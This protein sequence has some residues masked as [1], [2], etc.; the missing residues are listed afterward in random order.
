MKSQFHR[1]RK[2]K[3]DQTFGLPKTFKSAS[4]LIGMGLLGLGVLANISFRQGGNF[5]KT[6]E[7]REKLILGEAF[8]LENFLTLGSSDVPDPLDTGWYN[9]IRSLG[10]DDT[11]DVNPA[12]SHLDLFGNNDSS[13]LQTRRDTFFSDTIYYIRSRFNFQDFGNNAQASTHGSFFVGVDLDTNSTL[14]F[15][16]E[17]RYQNLDSLFFH[18]LNVSAASPNQISLSGLTSFHF[19]PTHAYLGNRTNGSDV[20]AEFGFRLGTLDS[21]VDANFAGDTIFGDKLLQFVFFSGDNIGVRDIA[22][23]N[24]QTDTTSTWNQLGIIFQ[25][26]LNGFVLGDDDGDGY[27][28]GTDSINNNPCLPTSGTRDIVPTSLTD[29]DGDGVP[30]AQEYFDGTDNFNG[31]FFSLTSFSVN[32]T[33][34]A[35]KLGDCDLDGLLNLLEVDYDTPDSLD[36]DGDGT[37]NLRDRDSDAD[38]VI[39]S[40]ERLNLTVILDSCSFRYLAADSSLQVDTMEV[41]LSW[42]NEDC[43]GDG[44]SNI[45]EIRAL[46]DPT[47]R[48]EFDTTGIGLAGI[49]AAAKADDCDGDGVD[50]EDEL[51][52]GTNYLDSCDFAFLVTMSSLNK[53]DTTIVSEA[54]KNADCDGDGISNINELRAL[55]DPTNICAFDTTGVG[56]AGLSSAV[57]A[58]DCDGD[59][60]TNGQ[61]ILDSTDYFDECDFIFENRTLPFTSNWINEDCDGDNIV[62]SVDDTL[63]IDLDSFRNYADLDTDGDGLSDSVEFYIDFTN[64][65]DPC[66]FKFNDQEYGSIVALNPGS[67]FWL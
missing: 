3:N 38:G 33:S 63:D 9:R 7:S 57:L 19:Q 32:L 52:D 14:D 41:S 62:N 21:L 18:K 51:N 67:N 17:A 58:L 34:P 53:P 36:F 13:F 2:L 40:I 48:C 6:K 50:N 59:G 47:I 24:G 23:I 35:W 1:M 16:I 8:T 43:D 56:L 5:F 61:V 39:D 31:C 25:N 20:W 44:V 29:C 66:N 11:L 45:N 37:P 26:S 4:F 55:I 27:L 28:A 22:G 42:R 64:F 60:V 54:W 30:Y 65:N 10:F 46:T 12:Y 49:S 15:L